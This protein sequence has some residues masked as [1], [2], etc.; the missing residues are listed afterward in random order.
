LSGNKWTTLPLSSVGLFRDRS[1][2]GQRAGSAGRARSSGRSRG[3]T[4]GSTAALDD[5]LQVTSARDGL[6]LAAQSQAIGLLIEAAGGGGA[7]GGSS[8]ASGRQTADEG[9]EGDAAAAGTGL[10]PSAAVA[11]VGAAGS[12]PHSPSAARL[13][14][15]LP[16]IASSS[17][18]GDSESDAASV[19]SG[20]GGGGDGGE[21]GSASSGGS[22]GGEGGNYE[23]VIYVS[24]EGAAVTAADAIKQAHLQ[25][26]NISMD[27]I[28]GLL[29]QGGLIGPSALERAS[30]GDGSGVGSSHPLAALQLRL[31]P[32]QTVRPRLWNPV[33]RFFDAID[34]LQARGGNGPQAA[35]SSEATPLLPR[36]PPAASTDSAISA[37]GGGAPASP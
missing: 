18:E 33:D 2:G 17:A 22:D 26:R 32:T 23:A 21:G 37:S 15:A 5:V 20:D 10:P 29:F 7:G 3:H 24:G 4:A 35:S 6:Q 8:S 19:R 16:N 25:L 31:M 27:P 9:G 30:G 34:V 36:R 14:G 1:S 28:A 11:A 12:R 13:G